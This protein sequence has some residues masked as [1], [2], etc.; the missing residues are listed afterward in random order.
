MKRIALLLSACAFSVSAA[1]AQDGTK[2]IEYPAAGTFA[3]GIEASPIL[4]FVGNMFNG[5]PD[6]ASASRWAKG[7]YTLH[8][9]YF[10]TDNT[11]V[12]LHLRFNPEDNKTVTRKFV[13]DDA[14]TTLN[15]LSNDKVEDKQVA[16]KNDWRIAAGYQMFRGSGRLRGFYGGD[17]YYRYEKE[18][19]SYYYGNIM[20]SF[21]A[22]PTTTT[23]FQTGTVGT[24][25]DRTLNEY[26]GGKHSLGLIGFTG[27]EYYFISN[28]CIGFEVGLVLQGSIATRG[29][30]ISEKM[31]GAEHVT[32]EEETAPS[33]ALFHF[34]TNA[35][36]R[37]LK[38]PSGKG[39]LA[40]TG[41]GNFYIMFHF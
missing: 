13:K 33:N 7:D 28:A 9:R 17:V 15:P 10:L 4:D 5:N 14:A 23:D 29:K 16:W 39:G 32:M 11:A 12:R 24:P 40:G 37:D 26:G 35:G 18:T 20:N 8:G 36:K 2:T 22:T 19:K 3:V 21:N 41:Y 34:G 30:S 31:V 27:A 38:D 6:N 1:L 25:T